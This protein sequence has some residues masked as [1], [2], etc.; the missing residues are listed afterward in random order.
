MHNGM[1]LIKSFEGLKL[2]TYLCPAGIP[3]IGYGQTG[4]DVVMGMKITAKEAEDRLL[5]EYTKYETKVKEL[6]TKTLN[7]NQLGA[8]VSFAYNVGLG[9]LK[10]STLLKHLNAGKFAEASQEFVKWNKA[11]V[12]GRLTVLNGLTRRRLAE[13]DLFVLPI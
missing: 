6:L 3:T 10:V 13:R 9:S 8:V 11:R 2:E 4:P 1:D 7:E 12:K 5:K